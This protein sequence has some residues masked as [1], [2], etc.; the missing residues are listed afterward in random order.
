MSDQID[1]NIILLLICILLGS[2]PVITI[3][4]KL[5]EKSKSKPKKITYEYDNDN[6]DITGIININPNDLDTSFKGD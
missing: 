6:S 2:M 4:W 1:T 5:V 3:I